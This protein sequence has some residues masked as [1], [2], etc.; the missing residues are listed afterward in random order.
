[1]TRRTHRRSG[2][3]AALATLA[4]F[5][6]SAPALA[7]GPDHG[8]RHGHDAT[9]ILR[10]VARA[11]TCSLDGCDH[12]HRRDVRRGGHRVGHREVLRHRPVHRSGPRAGAHAII[13]GRCHTWVSGHWAV[14]HERICVSPA[15]TER[16]WIQ[17][18]YGTRYDACGRAHRVV[19]RAGHW[20][21]FTIPA[22]Y[23]TRARR[24]YREGHWQACGA[25]CGHGGIERL[26]EVRDHDR[27][28]SRGRGHR[29]G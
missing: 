23:E 27:G 25:R 14:T 9:S 4:L 21:T 8:A 12:D 11:L 29:R 19:V 13:D 22:R 15:R 10:D 17:P 18:V 1:M 2:A 7:G 3:I 20:D 5:T 16:V 28:R 26:R 6:V 24:V